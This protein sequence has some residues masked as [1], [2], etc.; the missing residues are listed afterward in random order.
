MVLV[1]NAAVRIGIGMT[2]LL[3]L[4]PVVLLFVGLFASIDVTPTDCCCTFGTVVMRMVACRFPMLSGAGMLVGLAKFADV[5]TTSGTLRAGAVAV[6][7]G[8]GFDAA[9][10]TALMVDVTFGES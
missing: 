10:A 8:A 3:L 7:V 2:E 6:V 1:S 4:L 9:W 5:V